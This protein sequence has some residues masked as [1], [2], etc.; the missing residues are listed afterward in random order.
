M[1]RADGG[2][3]LDW[4][5][6]TRDAWREYLSRTSKSNPF[7]L[8]NYGEASRAVDRLIPRRAIVCR[9]DL[10]V[11]LVQLFERKSLGIFTYARL[12][13]GPLF[14]E[15]VLPEERVA[16]LVQIRSEYRLLKGGMLQAMPELPDGPAGRK[17]L[18]EAGFRQVQTGYASAWLDLSEVPED[19][20]AAD[21][22]YECR[23]ARRLGL[24][25]RRNSDPRW[26]LSRYDRHRAVAG[27]DG[28]S[29]ALLGRLGDENMLVLE[30]WTDGEDEPIAAVLFLRHGQ[31]ATYQVG[32][33]TDAGRRRSAHNLLCTEGL[34]MLRRDGVRHVDLGGVDWASTPGIARFKSGMGG[35]PFQLVGTYV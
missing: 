27:Y 23:K 9:G 10:P 31:S 33:T 20:F 11:G 16:T 14:F 6:A 5:A 29:G 26:L 22:R 3:N 30:A 24:E 13:R 7:H 35:E 32:W 4:D 8:W 28:P 25:V 34:S 2:I 12:V 1:T 15:T 19:G 17:L 21:F 18:S